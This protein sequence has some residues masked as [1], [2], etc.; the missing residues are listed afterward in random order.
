MGKE[1]KIY[2]FG[3][4]LNSYESE[5]IEQ[6]LIKK[7]VKNIAVYN[8]CAVTE[9]AIRQ[10]KYSIRKK[11]RDEPNTKIVVTGCA[12]QIEPETFVDMKEVDK[13][14]GN[15]EKRDMASHLLRNNN[16]LVSDI[17]TNKDPLNSLSAGYKNK[18]RAFVEI[19][20][21][22]NHRCTFCVIPYGRGNLRSKP[23]EQIII[24][25]NDL[26]SK[27]HKEIILTG[28]DIASWNMENHNESSLGVLIEYILNKIPSLERLRLSS[29]DIIGFDEKLI[30]LIANNKRILPHIHL[31]LQSGD[32]LILKRMK[33]RHLREDAI[34]LCK[35]LKQRRPE[36][37]FGADLI[38]GFPTETEEMF[39]N[40]LNIVEEC[41]LDWIHAF[42]FSPRPGT[43][44]AKMPQNDTKIIK[45]RSKI[46]R[47]VAKKRKK[48][49]LENLVGKSIEVF[50]EKDNKGYSN[51][52]API[53]LIEKNIESGQTITALIKTS[54]ENF[55]HG[56]A[57]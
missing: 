43:P 44:A 11:R 54:D 4:R 18:T 40:T 6:D 29:M 22:C 2:T 8:S 46:L 28:V 1:P 55:A 52:F 50:V 31:S 12:A 25:I 51:Q 57:I 38:V 5:I 36:I 48:R 49:Y 27:G 16:H 35:E 17:M 14:I 56:I 13:V 15:S 10:V 32:N 53:K 23:K 34:E 47:E 20:N 39:Q 26:I 33:R 45:Q 9:E 41:Q 7:G 3:C 19:Q 21:G 24:E 42:P 30:E 37:S